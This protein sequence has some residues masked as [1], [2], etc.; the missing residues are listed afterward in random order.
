MSSVPRHIFS[1][2]QLR[3]SHG[4]LGKYFRTRDIDERNNNCKYGQLETVYHVLDKSRSAEY[5]GHSL[6][7]VFP[8]L[9]LRILLDT[10]KGLEAVVKF[11]GS[12]PQLVC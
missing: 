6:K 2:F 7:K 4:V 12:L 9:D 1:K 10:K 11:L 8:E 5:K 3:T